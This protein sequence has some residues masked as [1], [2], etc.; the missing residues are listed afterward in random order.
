MVDFQGGILT[1]KTEAARSSETLVLVHHVNRF[2]IPEDRN[3]NI[4]G[5]D[6]FKSI[7]EVGL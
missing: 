1:L 7:D 5:Y 4:D 2:Y 6:N 3:M